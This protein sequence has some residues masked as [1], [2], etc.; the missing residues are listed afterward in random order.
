MNETPRERPWGQEADAIA[1]ARA[2]KRA[3]KRARRKEAQ[4]RAT[5]R[6][7]TTPDPDAC[8]MVITGALHRHRANTDAENYVVEARRDEQASKM[9]APIFAVTA[10]PSDGVRMNTALPADQ[11]GG[12][13]DYLDHDFA[14]LSGSDDDDADDDDGDDEQLD[15]AALLQ[16]IRGKRM[17]E[18]FG[19]KRAVREPYAGESHPTAKRTHLTDPDDGEDDAAASVRGDAGE[20][21]DVVARE[22]ASM[23][24][25]SSAP[26]PYPDSA[27]PAPRP[28]FEGEAH[29]R[30]VPSISK[31]GALYRRSVHK[32]WFAKIAR[33][34]HL[35]LNELCTNPRTKQMNPTMRYVLGDFI[36]SAFKILPECCKPYLYPKL[37]VYK[38]LQICMGGYAGVVQYM[39]LYESP[40]HFAADIAF[41]M[42]VAWDSFVH[43][44][45]NSHPVPKFLLLAEKVGDLSTFDTVA[46]AALTPFVALPYKPFGNPPVVPFD[47]VTES[48]ILDSS[49]TPNIDKGTPD[50]NHYILMLTDGMEGVR[51]QLPLDI[52]HDPASVHNNLIILVVAIPGLL[53]RMPPRLARI[54]AMYSAL[55]RCRDID[56]KSPLGLY[57][58]FQHFTQAHLEMA[59]AI[60]KPRG[61]LRRI[62]PTPV[63]VLKK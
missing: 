54:L 53:V 29:T 25:A 2:E 10:D 5:W 56:A 45:A 51:S 61:V 63:P 9:M 47:D 4:Q 6:A 35:L 46:V 44:V 13:V 14:S 62:P 17:D 39:R 60:I 36:Y 26:A 24:S 20:A 48:L 22:A 27:G 52:I 7:I 34:E 21:A 37:Q 15:E 1:R 57:L 59:A 40:V 50:S 30:P 58:Y 11:L 12:A 19:R 3:R 18:V 31:F 41:L 28:P 55:E 16:M 43:R 33:I 42:A 8:S 32:P 38:F 49:L 23:Q